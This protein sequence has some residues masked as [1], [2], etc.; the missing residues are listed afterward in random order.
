MTAIPLNQTVA[1]GLQIPGQSGLLILDVEPMTP[2]SQAGL[3]GGD[4]I[5]A[6]DNAR[7]TDLKGLYS[8]AQTR[9]RDGRMVLKL[10]RRGN[11]RNVTVQLPILGNADE[12]R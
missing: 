10:F 11:E 3:M 8:H 6:V 1:E 12:R 5:L 7:V 2:F 9:A 4:V